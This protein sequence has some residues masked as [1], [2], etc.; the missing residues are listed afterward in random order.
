MKCGLTSCVPFYRKKQA[1][2]IPH[3][4]TITHLSSTH[5]TDSPSRGSNNSLGIGQEMRRDIMSLLEDSMASLA[6]QGSDEDLY[7]YISTSMNSLNNNSNCHHRKQQDGG[8]FHEGRQGIQDGSSR[9][10]NTSV[11][12]PR[13][14]AKT[15]NYHEKNG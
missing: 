5:H 12:T 9:K 2:S 13:N 15:Q 10:V 3:R 11:L 6:P 4:E 7:I 8:R 14:D 1:V